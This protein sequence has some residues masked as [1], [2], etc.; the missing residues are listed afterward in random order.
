MFLP[1]SING[2]LKEIQINEMLLTNEESQ[3]YGLVLTAEE[4]KE[5]IEVRNQV[6]KSY[7]R[8]E[9]DIGVTRKLIHN[10]CTSAFITQEDYET[11]INDLQEVFYYLKNETEDSIGDDELIYIIKDFFNN[12][13]GGSMELLMGRELEIFARNCRRK[14][15]QM[16]YSLERGKLEWE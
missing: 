10:F 13:C 9:L 3:K 12:S 11:T 7:G 5:I 14:N 16:D 4:V 6:L 2:A 1:S 15:Q 8:I